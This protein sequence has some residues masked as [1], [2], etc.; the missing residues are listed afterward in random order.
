MKKL[1]VTVLALFATSAFALEVNDHS[2]P[3]LGGD[4][5]QGQG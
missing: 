4:Q 2:R 1:L 3:S 5:N